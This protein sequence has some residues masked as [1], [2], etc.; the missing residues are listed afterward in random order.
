MGEEKTDNQS[1]DLNEVMRVRR[2][3]LARLQEMGVNPYPYGFDRTHF[4]REILDNSDDLLGKKVRVAGRLMSIR[5]HGKVGFAHV[6]DAA[7][8][9]QIYVRKD[10]IGDGNFAVFKLMDIGDFVGVTG[11]VFVTRTGETTI[12]ASEVELLAKTLR[13][14][15]IVKEKGE[16]D[17]RVVYDQFADKELRYRQR[18][19]DLVVNP[20]VRKVF[21]MRSKII[22]HM[23]R[24]LD[25]Q[26]FLE[27]ETPVLQPIYGGAS[28]RPFVTHH[29]TLDIDLYL[30]I[31]DEL[32]LKRLIVGGFDGVYEISKDFRNEGM[33]RFHNPEFTMMEVYVAFK[34]YHY[35]MEMVE[36]L[37]SHLAQEIFGRTKITHQGRKI[38][39]KPPWPRVKLFDSIKERT[40]KDLYGKGLEDLKAAA[41]ELNIEIE[42][43]WR[44][45]KIIDE[46]FSEKVEPHLIDPTFIID[47]PVELSPLAKRHR[48]DARLVE[49][50]EPFLVGREFGNAFSEL[51]DPVDQRER[52]LAQQELLESGDDEAQMLDEDFLRALE[53]GM[54]PTAGLGIGI[55]RLVMLF[56]DQPSI[57][58]VILFPQMRPEK[59]K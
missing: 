54:P 17:D 29:N 50:F 53:Y 52:F 34:D 12:R 32:Y 19:I 16:G 20:D 3:K 46:I 1:E 28:A 48:D 47:Y 40:G 49:R 7:G 15:P 25:D 30:R 41:K 57:R 56:A 39:L 18:Y 36:N 26:G 51:N 6:M 58:D 37:V 31:A 35:M 14:L 9:I 22:T 10:E 44:E 4:S 21:V 42:S 5:G 13:P 38:D 27:V 45:G 2:E 33:D 24:F 11:E 43:F 59:S 55:D 23:R 8:K